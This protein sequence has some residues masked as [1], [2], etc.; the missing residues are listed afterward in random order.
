MRTQEQCYSIEVYLEFIN[1]NHCKQEMETEVYVS[2]LS[3]QACQLPGMVSYALFRRLAG[4]GVGCTLSKEVFTGW[5]L[6]RG[7]VGA[8]PARKVFEVLRQDGQQV[9]DGSARIGKRDWRFLGQKLTQSGDFALCR[10]RYLISS[11]CAGN[12]VNPIESLALDSKVGVFG[13]VR[14]AILAATWESF[15][16]H[17]KRGRSG[18][19]AKP[20]AH[21]QSRQSNTQHF[22]KHPQMWS[23]TMQENQTP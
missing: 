7:L 17:P 14:L 4:S 1:S 12:A 10:Q 23:E 11:R 22:W 5:W 20:R 18:Q 19:H 9:R 15:M 21:H 16:L 6:G 3:L 13:G 8:T 2:C